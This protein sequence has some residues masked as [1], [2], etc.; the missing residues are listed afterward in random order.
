MLVF[1]ENPAQVQ[2]NKVKTS[3]DERCTTVIFLTLSKYLLAC[4]MLENSL[5]MSKINHADYLEETVF[6]HCKCRRILILKAPNANSVKVSSRESFQ[7]QK[8]LKWDKPALDRKFCCGIWK[9]ISELLIIF[10][11]HSLT[12]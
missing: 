8:K 11:K 6:K 12:L 4:L 7:R 1:S 10:I 9:F 5:F 2:E 3:I